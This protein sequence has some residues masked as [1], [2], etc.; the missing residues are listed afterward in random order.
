MQEGLQIFADEE[1]RRT[2]IEEY[3][4]PQSTVDIL[5]T[6]FGISSVCN[7]FGAIK[8]V[9]HYG[10]GPNDLVVTV[11]TDGLDRYG[12]VMNDMRR[13]Y[14]V[15]DRTE[16]VARVRQPVPRE[17]DRPHLG[18]HGREPASLA[19]P[20]VLHLGRAARE[21]CRGTGRAA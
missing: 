4:I 7:V 17:D 11:A 20:E 19:Q 5:A 10:L 3:D 12:S 16:A 13:D 9:K 14:G 21:N 2:L 6:R 18:R 15:V 8:T 1:G